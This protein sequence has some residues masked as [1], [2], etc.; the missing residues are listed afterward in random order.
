MGTGSASELWALE[1]RLMRH[2]GDHGLHSFVILVTGASVLLSEIVTMTLMFAT[3]QPDGHLIAAVSAFAVPFFVA[4]VVAAMVGRL[5]LVLHRAFDDLEE[6][7]RTDALTGITNRR[8]FAAQAGDLWRMRRQ[9]VAV[10]AMIDVDDFKTVND[11]YGH[12]TGDQVLIQ[13][14]ENL[15]RAVGPWE[16]QAAVGRF[17]GDEFAV[18]VLLDGDAQVAELLAA[19][20]QARDLGQACAGARA[21]VGHVLVTDDGVS[22]DEALAAADHALYSLKRSRRSLPVPIQDG[23][24][25]AL[26]E[27]AG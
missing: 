17:G 16:A 27:A 6:L 23:A 2:I 1:R 15:G 10:A 20:E 19:L 21:T 22:L 14:A 25:P 3:R 5:L 12:P 8:A 9:G 11:T 7:A 4:P 18:M 26:W 24:T 13:L